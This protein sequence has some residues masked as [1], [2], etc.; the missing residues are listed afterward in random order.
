MEPIKK[1]LKKY[2]GDLKCKVD[3]SN[4]RGNTVA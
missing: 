3:K 2:F 4:K 1:E